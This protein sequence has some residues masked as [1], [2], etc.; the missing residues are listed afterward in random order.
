MRSGR[1]LVFVYNCDRG[2]LSAIKDYSQ[3]RAA[4]KPPE[5][6]LLDLISSPVGIKKAWKRYIRELRIPSRFLYHDEYEE[7]FGELL[8]P[9]PA[10]FLHH[11]KSRSLFISADELARVRT[12]E[13]LIAQVQEKMGQISILQ[14]K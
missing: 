5:C 9:L 12:I 10:V 3:K 4:E 7:E 8:T 6:N 13:D 14:E 2:N 11:Q 1:L